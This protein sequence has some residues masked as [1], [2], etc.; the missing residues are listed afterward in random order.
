MDYHLIVHKNSVLYQI[1]NMN[2][3]KERRNLAR[4]A[5]ETIKSLLRGDQENILEIPRG[6]D[7]RKIPDEIE[8]GDRVILYG[9]IHGFCLSGTLL[10]LRLMGVKAEYHPNGFI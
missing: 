5:G 7:P 8:S 6:Q 9:G 10:T 3:N 4:K 2:T 1:E